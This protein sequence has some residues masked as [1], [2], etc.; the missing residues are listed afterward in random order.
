MV[1]SSLGVIQQRHT[2]KDSFNCIKEYCSMHLNE[3]TCP[4]KDQISLL[5]IT[6][7][8]ARGPNY[9]RSMQHTLMNDEEFCF[10]IDT[11]S[12]FI[13]HWDAELMTMWGSIQN[14]YAILSTQAPDHKILDQIESHPS[15][16][17]PHLCQP[18]IDAR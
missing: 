2:E 14:E 1:D 10:Q 17:L 16:S 13:K 3:K 15:T 18:T 11:H 7:Q 5:E 9:A 6:H 12:N 8:L 4:Y